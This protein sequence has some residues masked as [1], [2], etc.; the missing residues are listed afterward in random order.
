MNYCCAPDNFP[1]EKWDVTALHR[2]L[3]PA[4]PAV[5][6]DMF[7]DFYAWYL[8]TQCTCSG[9]DGVNFLHSSW[10]G[11]VFWTCDQNSADNTPMF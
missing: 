2:S 11:A 8:V 4:D 9:W 6:S 5:V 3:M 10:S 7:A 1:G